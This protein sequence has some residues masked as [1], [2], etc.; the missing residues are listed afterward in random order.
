VI[1]GWHSRP[2]RL[3]MAGRPAI[4]DRRTPSW[5]PLHRHYNTK[6]IAIKTLLSVANATIKQFL[7]SQTTSLT[8]N[9]AHSGVP[10]EKNTA[11][12]HGSNMKLV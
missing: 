12:V 3:A 4:A 2:W 7:S 5:R 9:F 6:S 10:Q 1:A 11:M 8:M